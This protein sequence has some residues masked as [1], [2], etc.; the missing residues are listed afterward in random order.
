[1]DDFALGYL[2]HR[3]FYRIFE[4]FYHWYYSGSRAIAR[5]FMTTIEGIDRTVA[6][7]ITL[8]HFFEPLYKDY[9][10]IGRILG[11]VFRIARVLVG[12]VI[13]LVVVI[14]FIA[15]YLLWIAIPLVIIFYAIKR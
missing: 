10:I 15:L 7:K 4:F 6:I 1:M 2:I 3:F 12:L 11:I 13:Y 8:E 5:K 14:M 9:S